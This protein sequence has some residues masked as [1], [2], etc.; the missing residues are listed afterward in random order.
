MAKLL[1]NT[2]G[3]VLMS[4][5]GKVYK[6]PNYVE[7]PPVTNLSLS[8]QGL[9]SWNAPDIS[10]L[11]S[12]GYT[13][14]LSYELYING[15]SIGMVTET[16]ANISAYLSNGNNTIEIAVKAEI[17]YFD[18]IKNETSASW[19]V[20]SE[21]TVY[22]LTAILPYKSTYLASA[23]VNN[24]IYIFGFRVQGTTTS[25]YLKDVVEFDPV[26][27]TC[28]VL[29]VKSSYGICNRNAVVL[30][31][32]I[33]LLGGFSE[34]GSAVYYPQ[35]IE[36]FDPVSKTFSTLTRMPER[37]GRNATVAVNNKIY[38]FGGKLNTATDGIVEFDPVANTC[39]NLSI[40]LPIKI[41]SSCGVVINNKAYIFGGYGDSSPYPKDTI[42]E[43]NPEDN[44]CSLLDLTLPY[45]VYNASAVVINNKA[46]IFGGD[47]SNYLNTI[48][49]F[50]PVAN[51]CVVLDTLLPYKHSNMTASELNN[52]CYLFG[53]TIYGRIS[54]YGTEN[55]NEILRVDNLG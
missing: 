2:S 36:K 51:T 38:M 54:T 29:D 35:T 39:S 48:I 32:I 52:K 27:N 43:F 53:G 19:T 1:I 44:T 18:S 31:N 42:I 6:A 28:V 23:A 50:D 10:K 5:S 20:S 45:T 17:K 22:T 37:Y 24:K 34:N 33:Y 14:T 8:S 7:I 9:L 21:V 3:K 12:K 16:S 13:I 41:K 49:E 26:A 46:Y 4:E 40:T 25:D 30:D 47:S 11:E 15:N 55:S